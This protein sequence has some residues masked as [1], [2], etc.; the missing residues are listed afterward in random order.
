M[1]DKTLGYIFALSAITLF[2]IQ[3]GISKYLATYY[4]AVIV[5][6]FRYWAFAAFAIIILLRSGRIRASL[7]SR[8]VGLQMIRSLLLV[9]QIVIMVVSFTE[10]GIAMSQAIIQG[11]PLLV[12]ILAVPL[13][14]ERIGWQ[15]ILAVVFG[16]VGVLLII[17]PG[18]AG[19]DLAL[20]LPIY[21]TVSF[22]FYSIIT[23]A[24]GRYDSATTSVLYTSIV[25]A[26]A[27]SFIGPYY[28]VPIELRHW[29][30][31]AAICATGATS[32]Y[33][34]IIAYDKLEAGEVQPLSYFQLVFGTIIAVTVF[35]EVLRWN[36]ILGAIMVVSA[37]L[38]TIWREYIAAQRR[39]KL[40]T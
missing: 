9:S 6:M 12:T 16:L 32:H 40:G 3:D 29:G 10:V 2:S 22:A 39:R 30:W 19:F 7:K 24:V 33:F 28:W 25:G 37:G 13:L 26:I 18:A 38:F 8:R 14:G 23:R 21:G 34:L 27:I 11:T 15:R 1:S 35:N 20:L 4:P 31:M 5:V 17:N 36:M